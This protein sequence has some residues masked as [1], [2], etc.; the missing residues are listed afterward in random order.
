MTKKTDKIKANLLQG[1]GES[2]YVDIVRLQESPNQYHTHKQKQQNLI[3]THKGKLH[4]SLGK[5]C[6]H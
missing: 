6:Y 2:L 5:I 3:E 4:N 1:L